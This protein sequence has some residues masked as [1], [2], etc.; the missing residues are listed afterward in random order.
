MK[1][2][3][4]L[5]GRESEIEAES[6]RTILDIALIARLDPPF[7]CMEGH[8]GTCEALIEG[9]VVRTCQT[10]PSSDFTIVDYDKCRI[11]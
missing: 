3:F 10:V 8:C 11:K 2:K 6:G 9:Q 7:S 1:I 4:I 5:N